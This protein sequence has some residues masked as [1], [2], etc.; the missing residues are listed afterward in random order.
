MDFSGADFFPAILKDNKEGNTIGNV[1]LG[2]EAM[3]MIS[4]SPTRT[5]SPHVHIQHRLRKRTTKKRLR[6]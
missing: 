1:L 4:N 3:Y 2:Q 6:T 5:E